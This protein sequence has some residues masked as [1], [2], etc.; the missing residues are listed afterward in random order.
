MSVKNCLLYFRLYFLCFII[1][2]F[3]SDIY[4]FSKSFDNIYPIIVDN[5]RLSWHKSVY[6]LLILIT[7]TLLFTILSSFHSYRVQ[8]VSCIFRNE[9]WEHFIGQNNR[10]L[11]KFSSPFPIIENDKW[12]TRNL[13]WCERLCDA[14]YPKI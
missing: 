6:S 4:G 9:L 7:K 1:L 3:D 10:I 8:K 14:L 2:Y 11:I 5:S 12:V 13:G